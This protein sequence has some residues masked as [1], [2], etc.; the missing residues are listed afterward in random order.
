MGAYKTVCGKCAQ[1]IGKTS[2]KIGCNG[3]CKGYYHTKCAG[4]TE[5]E[6]RLMIKNKT[7]WFCIQC[8]PLDNQKNTSNRSSSRLDKMRPS[9]SFYG[10]PSSTPNSQRSSTA[11]QVDNTAGVLEEVKASREEMQSFRSAFE[12]F[13]EKYEEER[14]KNQIFVEML[15]DIQKENEDMKKELTEVK[16]YINT[17][18]NEKRGKN[19]ILNGICYSRAEDIQTIKV[20]TMKMFEFLKVNISEEEI[21]VQKIL[22]KGQSKMPLVKIEVCSVDKKKRNIK[23]KK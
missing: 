16:N 22:L 23:K 13:N 21:K 15:H 3:K 2:Y 19:L 1:T 5:F 20:K 18:E 4:L 7:S 8:K 6:V 12:F 11:V 10:E 17:L 9:I 14:R